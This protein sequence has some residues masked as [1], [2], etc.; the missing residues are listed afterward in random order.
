LRKRRICK[1][2]CASQS[3]RKA[4]TIQI[5]AGN[6]D[7]GAA[8]FADGRKKGPTSGRSEMERQ[9]NGFKLQSGGSRHGN[10]P[11]KK[12]FSGREKGVIWGEKKKRREEK[13]D[14]QDGRRQGRT[15][16]GD[17]DG[18]GTKV[19]KETSPPGK[20]PL[21]AHQKEPGRVPCEGTREEVGQSS[22]TTAEEEKDY[23]RR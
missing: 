12:K 8:N 10:H 15:A 2:S 3:T 18:E 13:E 4:V 16:R 14:L 22:R 1:G 11:K 20:E 6:R 23:G 5:G 19:V 9:G 21:A 17:N 7:Q